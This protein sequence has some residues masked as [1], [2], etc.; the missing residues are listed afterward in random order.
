ME[1]TLS[2]GVV[3]PVKMKRCDECKD[4]M[5]YMTCNNQDNQNKASEGYL[6][7]LKRESLNQFGHMLLYYEN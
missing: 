7:S 3:I 1:K 5:L 2:K 4:G 6:N